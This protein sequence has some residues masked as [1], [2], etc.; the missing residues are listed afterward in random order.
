M[1]TPRPALKDNMWTHWRIYCRIIK[2]VKRGEAT[3]LRPTCGLDR[4]GFLFDLPGGLTVRMWHGE[5]TFLEP[6]PFDN[7]CIT[8]DS[9][10]LIRALIAQGFQLPRYEPPRTAWGTL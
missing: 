2:A 5:S 9:R 6:S 1:S 3:N 7:P 10:R 8:T 4:Y